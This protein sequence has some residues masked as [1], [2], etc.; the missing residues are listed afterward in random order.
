MVVGKTRLLS[1]YIYIFT[2]AISYIYIYILWLVWVYIVF[3]A[4]SYIHVYIVINM[5]IYR[6]F[7]WVEIPGT[8]SRNPQ[9]YSGTSTPFWG[10]LMIHWFLSMYHWRWS[11]YNSY[12][13]LDTII[14]V[15]PYIWFSRD[16]GYIYQLNQVAPPWLSADSISPV[17]TMTP[18]WD[19]NGCQVQL[20]RQ[21]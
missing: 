19:G 15:S 16:L 5:S 4:I 6:I 2:C 17:L 8:P 14:L 18:H 20:L 9:T 3:R 1:K 7:G 21:E 12:S 13:I 10:T 11:C